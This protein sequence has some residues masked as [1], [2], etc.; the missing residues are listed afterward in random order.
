MLSETHW[1]SSSLTARHRVI[2]TAGVSIPPRRCA[3][4]QA[5]LKVG[6]AVESGQRRALIADEADL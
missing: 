2:R 1:T 3:S 6:H 4:S 5:N